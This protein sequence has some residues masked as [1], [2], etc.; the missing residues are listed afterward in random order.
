MAIGATYTYAS[1]PDSAGVI[2][3][4]YDK[5]GLRV[6]DPSNGAACK[7]DETSLNWSQSGPQVPGASTSA[8][9]FGCRHDPPVIS[10]TRLLQRRCDAG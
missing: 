7:N 2:H 10:R 5:N 9:G 1:I 6:I 3:G 4:C 8:A